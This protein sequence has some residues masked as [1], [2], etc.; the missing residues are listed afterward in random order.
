MHALRNI[1]TEMADVESFEEMIRIR[2]VAA[3]ATESA[4]GDRVRREGGDRW[5]GDNR[6]QSPAGRRR[7]VGGDNRRR[8]GGDGW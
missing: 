8:D 4:G 7:Q 6:R 3:V 1:A 5:G 2:E